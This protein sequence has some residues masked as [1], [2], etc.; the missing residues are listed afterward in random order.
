MLKWDLRLSPSSSIFSVN[1]RK[2]RC[3]NLYTG[4]QIPIVNKVQLITFYVCL[5]ST[6]THREAFT[7]R[8]GQSDLCHWTGTWQHKTAQL[9]TISN[10]TQSLEHVLVAALEGVFRPFQQLQLD[11]CGWSLPANPA[12]ALHSSKCRHHL[13]FPSSL[14]V[15]LWGSCTAERWKEEKRVRSQYKKYKLFNCY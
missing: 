1:T 13:P 5:F 11:A 6:N 9:H 10:I 4:P 7:L 12:G 14:A 3:K 8:K 2:H 15:L